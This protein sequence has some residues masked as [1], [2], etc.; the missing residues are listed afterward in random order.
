MSRK[1]TTTV[2]IEC[3]DDGVH[4]GK[5]PYHCKD[6]IILGNPRAQCGIKEF[7]RPLLAYENGK[8]IRCQACLDAEREAKERKDG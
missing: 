4:C 2:E 1:F 3:H 8:F 5:Y 6:I 7:G